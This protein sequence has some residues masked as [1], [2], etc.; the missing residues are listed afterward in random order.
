MM[1]MQFRDKHRL[2]LLCINVP[3]QKSLRSSTQTQSSA[4]S[5]C[6]TSRATSKAWSGGGR[7]VRGILRYP[8][9][10]AEAGLRGNGRR[11][12]RDQEGGFSSS[13]MSAHLHLHRL[14]ISDDLTTSTQ[15]SRVS[16]QHTRLPSL[17]WTIVR[18]EDI[19]C[20]DI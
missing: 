12:P 9:L 4:L 7:S 1:I 19:L 6:W 8:R 5:W 11:P 3:A 18:S 16:L 10:K 15:N 17:S 20:P 13:G 2:M 14:G